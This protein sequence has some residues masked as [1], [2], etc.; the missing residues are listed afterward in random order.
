MPSTADI[1]DITEPKNVRNGRRGRR[2]RAKATKTRSSKRARPQRRRRVHATSNGTLER[3][4]R[5]AKA[6]VVKI[7]KAIN[8]KRVYEYAYEMVAPSRTTA[9]KPRR[10][11]AKR[12]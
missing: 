9:K 5:A 10:R 1:S 2:K 8:A 12:S 4:L 3:M 6:R 7:Q 11:R